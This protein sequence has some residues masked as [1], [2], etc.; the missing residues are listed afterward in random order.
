MAIHLNG[1]ITD[2]GELKLDLPPDLPAGE[3][4]ITIE[5][6]TESRAPEEV[7]QTLTQQRKVAWRVH[8]LG[9]T[10][11][12]WLV[13]FKKVGHGGRVLYK[14][15]GPGQVFKRPLLTSAEC[16]EAYAVS[17]DNHLRHEFS[18]KYQ[19]EA[20]TWTFTLHFKL[21]FRVGSAERLAASLPEQDPLERFQD[22]AASVLSSTA[23]RLSWEVITQE[24][25]DF[26]LRLRE[27]ETMDG[28]GE[29]RTNFQRLQI[30]ADDLGLELRH[31][32]V[33][34]SF[35]ESDLK[36]LAKFKESDHHRLISHSDQAFRAEREQFTNEIQSLSYQFKMGREAALAWSSQVLEKLERLRLLLDAITREGVRGIQQSVIEAI[37]NSL[38]EIRGI[39]TSLAALSGRAAPALAPGGHQNGGEAGTS[40]GVQDL[41]WALTT[42]PM[43]GAE[44]V[45]AGLVGGWEEMGIAD[46]ASWVDE[47]RSKRRERRQ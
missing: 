16:Y 47:Q 39:Q 35:S 6:P 36:G 12:N 14:V 19:A 27:T 33:F 7:A 29:C 5:I 38:N 31:L 30:F 22:E 40:R 1:L 18:R 21:Y 10:P 2:Q 4:R 44:I 17:A 24:G 41:D 15:L 46:G 13:I 9:P 20:Q 3:A 43:T 34:R 23:R 32:D 45:K 42:E 11:A 28:R 26:G 8:D 25:D 37:H